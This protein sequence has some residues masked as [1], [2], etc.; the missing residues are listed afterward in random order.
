ME[1]ENLNQG[2]NDSGGASGFNPQ[3][4]PQLTPV[5]SFPAEGGDVSVYI[6]KIGFEKIAVITFDD[7]HREFTYAIQT[8]SIEPVRHVKEIYEMVES[9]EKEFSNPFISNPFSKLL[10]DNEAMSE[11]LIVLERFIESGE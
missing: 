2:L 1:K 7:T 4:V 6:A 10:N 5:F 11:L 9:A 8:L 3:S